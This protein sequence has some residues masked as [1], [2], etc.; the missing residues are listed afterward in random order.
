MSTGVA[1]TGQERG[2]RHECAHYGY[3]ARPETRLCENAEKAAKSLG[4]QIRHF[5]IQ[6]QIA[7]ARGPKKRR[8]WHEMDERD[9]EMGG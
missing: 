3:G 4:I 7:L 5:S 8:M 2:I 1:C 6:E 9:V